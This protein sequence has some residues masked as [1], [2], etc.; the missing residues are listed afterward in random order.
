MAETRVKVRL[1]TGQAKADLDGLTREASRTAGRAGGRIRAAVGRGL[2]LVG[3]GAAVGAGISAVRGATE[4]GVG[5]VIGEAFGGYGKQLEQFF[6]GNMA[7]GA[8][9]DRSAR[10][11]TIQAFAAQVGANNGVIPPGAKEYFDQVR[12]L[13]MER[14]EGRSAIE[15]DERFRNTKPQDMI[16]QILKG[17]NQIVDDAV[18]ALYQKLVSWF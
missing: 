11:A 8:K 17:L 7:D 10:E 13:H 14:E 12:S 9:A 15:R 18:E 1:D 4:S 5:D 16:E 2:G 3:A 6:L